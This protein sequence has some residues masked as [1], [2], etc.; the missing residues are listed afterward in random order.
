[1]KEMKVNSK[2]FTLIELLAVIVILAIIALIATP[3]ILGI[4]EDARKNSGARSVEGYAKAI[5]SAVTSYMGKH[6]DASV[7]Q[8]NICLTV[9]GTDEDIECYIDATAD[10]KDGTTSMTGATPATYDGAQVTC[11]SLVYSDAGHLSL[12]GCKVAG[13]DTE[14]TYTSTTG[15]DAQE[16][17]DACNP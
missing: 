3:I 15:A 2:G 11:E 16:E 4:I 6:A 13:N 5:T 10:A 1:V 7:K 17:G 14:Y 8:P 12:C 9:P